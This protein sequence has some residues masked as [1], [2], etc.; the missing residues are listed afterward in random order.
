MNTTV[1]IVA[2]VF[3]AAGLALIVLSFVVGSSKPDGEAAGQ[4]AAEGAAFIDEP[5]ATDIAAQL[6]GPHTVDTEP[7]PGASM[8]RSVEALSPNTIT[9]QTPEVSEETLASEIPMV[10]VHVEAPEPAL[11][12]APPAPS[13]LS[14]REAGGGAQKVGYSFRV[15]LGF[16]FLKNGLHE[17][18]I[19]EFQKALALTEDMEVKLKLCIEIGNT[20][21]AEKMYARASAAY[22]QATAFTDNPT[23]LEHLERSIAEMSELEDAATASA[24]PGSD[25][26]EK[27]P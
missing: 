27:A 5:L 21:R 6:G 3:V 8:P 14:G 23:L 17:D 11:Q 25:K 13:G 12:K 4:S 20:L 22:L 26:E 9:E 1:L 2:G 7:A 10:E 15:Q 19:A 24:Q 18:A 16:K